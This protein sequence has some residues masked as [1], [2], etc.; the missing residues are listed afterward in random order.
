MHFTKTTLF[1]DEAFFTLI[2]ITNTY[3][4]NIYCDRYSDATKVTHYQRKFRCVG[5]NN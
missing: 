3:N 2:G 1:S 5:R 4:D